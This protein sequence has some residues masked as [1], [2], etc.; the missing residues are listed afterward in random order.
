MLMLMFLLLSPLLFL[1]LSSIVLLLLLS[2]LSYPK[3]VFHKNN[4]LLSVSPNCYHYHI[5]DVTIFIL[6]FILIFQ[7]N[8]PC[9]YISHPVHSFLLVMLLWNQNYEVT[10]NI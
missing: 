10:K 5:I 4:F 7:R 9:T 2:L 6:F 8:D 3:Y 1:F